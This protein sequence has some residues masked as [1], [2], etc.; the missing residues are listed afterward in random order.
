[1]PELE[2]AITE[3]AVERF[4]AQPTLGFSLQ[5]RNRGRAQVRSVILQ[6]QLRIEAWRRPYSSDEQLRLKELFGPPRAWAHSLRSL[7][8]TYVHSTIS[9]TGDSARVRLPV[10]CSYDF[11]LT[12]AKYL[13]G[14]NEGEVPLLFLFSGTIL[15]EDGAGAVRLS[16]IPHDREARFRLPV[17]CWRELMDHY[18]PE[19]AWLLLSRPV[20]D[21]LE[22]YKRLEGFLG[23]DGALESLLAAQERR[24]A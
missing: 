7:L 1:M 10:P 6:C 18:Y 15:Y 12:V 17:G 14:L 24:S 22:R 2:F 8:W 4:A 23:W 16:Q 21:R 11:N 20:F 9:F 3:A 13:Y 19:T 5:V